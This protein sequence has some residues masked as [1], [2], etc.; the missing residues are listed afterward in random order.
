[1]HQA[2][3]IHHNPLHPGS[4]CGGGEAHVAA[5]HGGGLQGKDL[6]PSALRPALHFYSFVDIFLFISINFRP[7]AMHERPASP[8]VAV[9]PVVA[10]R[11]QPET[12][13]S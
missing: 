7:G 4:P 1:M 9:D 6:A 2:H 3:L 12:D 8:A 11:S 5:L 10:E 13:G